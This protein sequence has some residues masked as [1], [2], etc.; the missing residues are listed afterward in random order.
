MLST[1]LCVANLHG[2]SITFIRWLTLEQASREAPKERGVYVI[3]GKDGRL[4]DRVNGESDII[5]IGSSKN[6]RRRM[7]QYFKPIRKASSPTQRIKRFSEL[8]QLEVAFAQ[9]PDQ[10][11]P[12]F[13][14]AIALQEYWTAHHEFPPVN[15]STV[16]KHFLGVTRLRN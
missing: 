3:R 6:L 16:M 15:H 9:T 8:Y 13:Y 5:Y 14:E 7:K 2:E 1:E 12:T 4:F 10:E 11:E